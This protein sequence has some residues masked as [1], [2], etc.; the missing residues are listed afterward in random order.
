MI[1]YL[2]YTLLTLWLSL[3]FVHPSLA[4]EGWNTEKFKPEEGMVD[5]NTVKG[6]VTLKTGKKAYIQY[7]QHG[8]VGLGGQV[9][10]SNESL[11]KVSQTHVEQHNPYQE[12]MTGND[13]AT[14]TVVLEAIKKG[15]VNLT[16]NEVFRGKTE[17]KMSL[18][19]SVK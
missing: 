6:K 11:L 10:I 17:K 5:L 2:K 8:S 16:L 7:T 9:L 18:K 14:V 19:V 3:I 1:N 12:G 15:T 13:K 4:Q